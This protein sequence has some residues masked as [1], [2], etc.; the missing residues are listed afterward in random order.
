MPFDSK[1]V[2][3]SMTED[4]FNSGENGDS[5]EEELTSKA[6]ENGTLDGYILDN[7]STLFFSSLRSISVLGSGLLLG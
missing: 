7:S 1:H 5:K 3:S 6:E 2:F 4:D